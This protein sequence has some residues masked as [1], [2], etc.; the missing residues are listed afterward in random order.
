MEITN[1]GEAHIKRWKFATNEVARLKSRLNKA[2]CELFNSGAALARWL[3]PKDAKANEL[4]CVWYGDSLI[5]AKQE[6][7]GSH[8][9]RLRTRGKGWDDV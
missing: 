6:Q 2:E 1:E 4:F 9:V 3:M 5:S 8:S 7:G